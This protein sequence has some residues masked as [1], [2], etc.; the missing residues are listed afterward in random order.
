MSNLG[1]R[2]LS[3]KGAP[4]KILGPS[5][6]WPRNE[7]DPV[8]DE[9][10]FDPGLIVEEKYHLLTLSEF[11]ERYGFLPFE[12][13]E[14]PLPSASPEES[15]EDRRMP[16]VGSMAKNFM[17]STKQLVGNGFASGEVQAERIAIC[18]A[19]PSF[20][21]N[22]RRCRECGC[23]MDAKKTIGGDGKALCPLHK[24]VN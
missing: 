7:D 4:Y 24:W 20:D 12:I 9:P 16:G 1:I 11:E 23:F 17:N 6:D 2:K 8:A 15:S 19:C 22:S 5:C 13:I 14:E 10:G 18:E 3:E 21:S